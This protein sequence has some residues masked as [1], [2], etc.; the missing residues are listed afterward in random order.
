MK[1]HK[2]P[3]SKNVV[4]ASNQYIIKYLSKSI[5]AAF[6]L[7]YKSLEIEHNKRKFYSGDDSFW[8]I[9]STTPV[10]DTFNKFISRKTAT[11]VSAHD[12]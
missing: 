8:L 11:S 1:M 10:V 12:L 7:L 3:V 4:T 5:L 9:Q 2:A 6:K